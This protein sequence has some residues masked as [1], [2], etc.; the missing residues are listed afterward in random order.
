MTASR[1]T[2]AVLRFGAGFRPDQTP[3]D[4]PEALLAELDASQDAK[5]PP[6]IS[7]EEAAVRYARF[8]EFRALRRKGRKGDDEKSMD[9]AQAIVKTARN[10]MGHDDMV[11][12]ARAVATPL[13]F[14]ERLQ[15]F[16]CD[17]FTV[18]RKNPHHGG[19]ILP[20][21]E[22]A[23]RPNLGGR[24]E[25]MLVA[26]ATSPAMTFYL[27]QHT[28]AG[29]DSRTARE[30]PGRGLNENLAREILE[31]HTLGVHG[32]YT[33]ND[34]R[35]FARLL[36][37]VSFDE[38]GYVFKPRLADPGEKV[39]LGRR[40]V[41]EGPQAPLGFLRWLAA[42]P[43]TGRHLAGKMAKHFVSDAPDPALVESMDEAYADT[44]GDLRAMTGAMLVHP[45]AWAPLGQPTNKVKKPWDLMVSG[46][47]AAGASK[48]DVMNQKR[49]PRD[50]TL[51][52]LRD[53]GQPLDDAPGPDGWKEEADAWIT[54][55]G[56]AARLE[57]AGRAGRA[58]GPQVDPREF[59]RTAL[60]DAMTRETEFAVRAASE[61]WEGVALALVSP[62]FNRR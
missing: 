24:F 54:P 48:R 44:G 40:H 57:W 25:D 31:L 14:R 43:A 4:G 13:G 10:E 17:H 21:Q 27:D 49:I 11:R 56:M 2:I 28:S 9:A 20:M 41:G 60:R 42:H 23:I 12:I 52:A 62:D 26:V 32:P 51:G 39:V 30:H 35:E 58:M 6:L 36:A 61:K 8:A 19:F 29:P 38:N 5:F 18:A 46:L 37:G 45:A 22:L 34:V 47:R 1:A 3:P 50:V 55:G 33:Q 7:A 15:R 53:M 16:W 59:A